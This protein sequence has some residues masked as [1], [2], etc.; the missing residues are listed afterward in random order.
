ME[1][2]NIN[3]NTTIISSPMMRTP[4]DYPISAAAGFHYCK[5]LSPFKAMEWLYVDSLKSL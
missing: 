2:N 5:V 3:S 4:I 1:Y